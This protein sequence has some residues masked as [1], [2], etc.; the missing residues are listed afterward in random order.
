MRN[1]NYKKHL[2]FAAVVCRRSQNLKI[3]DQEKQSQTDLLRFIDEYH[4]NHNA[5]VVHAV[6]FFSQV[7]LILLLFLG[8]VMYANEVET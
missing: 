5:N 7:I 3:I 4:I 6:N 2:S 8:M 1:I